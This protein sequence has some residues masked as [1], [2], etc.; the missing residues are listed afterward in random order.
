M[1]A[2]LVLNE[3]NEVIHF[4]GNYMDYVAIAPGKASFN[5]FNII[6]KDLKPGG[7]HRLKPLPG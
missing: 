1:P 5:L 7:L 6:N 3:S 4:F 2:S